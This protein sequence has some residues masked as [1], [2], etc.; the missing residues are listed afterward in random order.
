MF[1]FVSKSAPFLGMTL[2]CMGAL[3]DDVAV[4]KAEN[5][6]RDSIKQNNQVAKQSVIVIGKDTTVLT[7]PLDADGYVDFQAYLN[8]VLSEGATTENNAA[9]LLWHAYGPAYI[10]KEHRKEFFK[11]LGIDLLPEQGDYFRNFE[12][13]VDDGKLRVFAGLA[14][15][16]TKNEFPDVARWLVA[17]D[18][19]LALVVTASKRPKLYQPLVGGSPIMEQ[20]LPHL[21]PAGEVA[22][23]L[24]ARAMLRVGEGN[25][26]AAR[27]DLKALRQLAILHDQRLG[28]RDTL[29]TYVLESIALR[30]YAGLAKCGKLSAQQAR[31][32]Q[33][34]IAALPATPLKDRVDKME[35]YMFIDATVSFARKRNENRDN[36]N[37]ES[38][39]ID[40]SQALRYGNRQYDRV[41]AILEATTYEVQKEKLNAIRVELDQVIKRA[42][43]GGLILA[44]L[45]SSH[46][47]ISV[48]LDV[49]AARLTRRQLVATSF[50]LAAYK[51]EKGKYPNHLAKLIPSY[52][53]ELPRD[54]FSGKPPIY[55]RNH[56][57]Y[58]LYSVGR[59]QK[60][61]SGMGRLFG[62]EAD[63]IDV[64]SGDQ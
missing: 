19:A 36:E 32:L 51:S 38:L 12:E 27:Q 63:D 43:E 45:H 41:V 34:E 62:D 3:S 11:H 17:N 39:P 46:G 31:E 15:S 5:D 33:A 21:R 22:R 23:A 54:Y 20:P 53:N 56:D 49:H 13:F 10:L 50:A 18:R 42:T 14:R 1:G 25:V 29:V 55:K 47:V 4:Q 60:D 9:V 52:V 40:W 8:D 61:D 16:W 58:V 6:Q 44:L 37:S 35:R 2:I 59:N 24:A 28:L 30:A 7:E 64:S 48:T 57:S 26:A